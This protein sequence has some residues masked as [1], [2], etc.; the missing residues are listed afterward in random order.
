MA[1]ASKTVTCV[2]LE[3]ALFRSRLSRFHQLF[4]RNETHQVIL[5]MDALLSL[6]AGLVGGFF[7]KRILKVGQFLKLQ[8]QLEFYIEQDL[9]RPIFLLFGC[10][11][12]IPDRVPALSG[13]R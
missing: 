10:G 13:I 2:F 3:Q 12:N 7:M 5:H 6:A 9:I 11:C 1:V 4:H 8:S